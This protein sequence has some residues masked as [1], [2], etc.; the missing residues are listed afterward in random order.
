MSSVKPIV[1]ENFDGRP[2]RSNFCTRH[3]AKIGQR[4]LSWIELKFVHELILASSELY[5]G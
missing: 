3:S 2:D 1:L 5:G 4:V